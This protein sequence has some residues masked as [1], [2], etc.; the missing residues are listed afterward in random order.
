MTACASTRPTVRTKMSRVR[1]RTVPD[2]RHS[3]HVPPPQIRNAEPSD[4]ERI[5]PLVDD[6]WGGR[7]MRALLPRLFF[8]H[9]R[10]TSFV[11]EE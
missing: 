7:Q 9:F 6:W 11:A 3:P 1:V 5:S 8:E 4:Y 10:E 2:L